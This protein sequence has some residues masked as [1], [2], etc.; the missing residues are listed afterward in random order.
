MRRIGVG[1]R[2]A[3]VV[4]VVALAGCS[5]GPEGVPGPVSVPDISPALPAVEAPEFGGDVQGVEAVLFDRDVEGALTV[6]VRVTSAGRPVVEVV[7]Q[8]IDTL[9]DAFDF[10]MRGAP[11]GTVTLDVEVSTHRGLLALLRTLMPECAVVD[12]VRVVVDC[13]GDNIAYSGPVLVGTWALAAEVIEELAGH[14]GV[15][16]KGVERYTVC[17]GEV[18]LL[19]ELREAIRGVGQLGGDAVRLIPGVGLDVVTTIAGVV[20][21]EVQAVELGG[22]VMVAGVAGDVA[23]VVAAVDALGGRECVTVRIPLEGGAADR[24]AYTALIHD[25]ASTALCGEPYSVSGALVVRLRGVE[26][27]AVVGRVRA[28]LEA[29]RPV[30]GVMVVTLAVFDTSGVI[31]VGSGRSDQV[32][33]TGLELARSTYRIRYS[34]GVQSWRSTTSD[35]VDAGG[36][37]GEGGVAAETVESRTVG[38]QIEFDGVIHA[39]VFSGDVGWSDT[40]AVERG[41]RGVECRGPVVVAAEDVVLCEYESDAAVADWSLKGVAQGLGLSVNRLRYRVLVRYEGVARPRLFHGGG[42][43]GTNPPRWESGGRAGEGL[44]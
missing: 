43:P 4:V 38:V 27:A 22:G 13:T 18:H 19:Q 36:E 44:R 20:A 12:G 35:L 24:D 15:R 34:G 8:V 5:W 40:S 23:E 32:P 25:A 31:G 37:I 28:V 42:S 41:S 17:E 1:A 33:G 7:T 10:V 21:P 16:C 30:P 6:P 9:P 29:A 11:V 3:C 39:G 26:G 14:A 2:V